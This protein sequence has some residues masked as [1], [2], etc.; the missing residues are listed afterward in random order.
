MSDSSEL[1]NA[2]PGHL[3]ALLTDVTTLQSRL[4]AEMNLGLAASPGAGC[5]PKHVTLAAHLTKQTVDLS[6]ELR[7]WTKATKDRGRNLSIGERIALTVAF[8]RSL[9]V[10]DR[11]E[12]ER[13]LTGAP[14][15]G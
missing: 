11:R 12:F 14:D 10:A 3:Q 2:V 9:S 7:A 4:S 13:L 5:N 1:H 15:A 8:V 6:R